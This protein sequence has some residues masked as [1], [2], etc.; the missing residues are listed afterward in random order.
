MAYPTDIDSFTTRSNGTPLDASHINAL[1]SSMVAVQTELDANPSG[2]SATVR[3]RLDA[4]DA[5]LAGL[6]PTADAYVYRSATNT[7]AVD[8]AGAII[9]SLATTAANNVTVIQAAIDDVA[10]AYTPGTLT[11]LGHGG[12]G[13][14]RFSG[15]LFEVSAMID[16]KYG[17]SLE[18]NCI[19]DRN[20]SSAGA[21]SFQGTCFAPTSALGPVNIAASGGAVNRTPVILLGRTQAGSE[22]QSTT[23]PHNTTIRG[24][25]IDMR[26]ETTAQGIV[27]A[28]TQFVTIDGNA[29]CNATGAGGAAIEVVSTNT[30]DNGAHALDVRGNLLMNCEKGIVANGSGSTDSLVHDNRIL[31][32]SSMTIELGSSGGGGGWQILNNHFTTATASQTA[33][34]EGHLIIAGA[35]C[36]V[37][38]NYFDTTGGRSIYC[39]SPIVTITGNY[40]KH[41][42]T[43]FAPIFLTGTGRKAA[44]SSNVAQGSSSCRALVQVNS[45]SGQDYR[46]VV[47]GNLLGDGGNTSIVGI[48]C[49]NAGAVIAE[50]DAAMTIARDGTPNPY[51]WGNRIVQSAV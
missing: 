16:V 23:N 29:I 49:D 21:M 43:T 41:S 32:M 38:G 28:D 8:R 47:T 4:I 37:T 5:L 11:A 10:G 40:F 19:F 17:V 25:G 30:P 42:G 34:G 24:I 9:S 35:P 3:A 27:V 12:G 50:T 1:Q 46:P 36:M 31:I 45:T 13:L 7:I 6:V 26:R 2:A 18:G 48:V 51:I 33:A 44:V 39:S 14:V 22:V 15:Q 20:G